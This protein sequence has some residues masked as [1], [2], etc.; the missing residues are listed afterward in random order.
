MDFFLSVSIWSSENLIE[1]LLK[2]IFVQLFKFKNVT[3]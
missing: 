3:L 2:V 1:F